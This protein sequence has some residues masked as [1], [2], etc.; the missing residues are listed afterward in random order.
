MSGILCFSESNIQ[1]LMDFL[2]TVHKEEASACV[3]FMGTAL[4]ESPK[5]HHWL[6]SLA[7]TNGATRCQNLVTKKDNL[8]QQK[9]HGVHVMKHKSWYGEMGCV[10]N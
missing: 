10:V 4:A 1:F 2:C 5:E 7:S 8:W 6:M 3:L 9:K